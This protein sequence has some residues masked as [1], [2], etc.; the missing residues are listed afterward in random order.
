MSKYNC[1]KLLSL[2]GNNDN[3]SVFFYQLLSRLLKSTHPEDLQAANRLIKT[4]V[5][6][7]RS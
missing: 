7:V 1:A 2:T 4:M 3:G 5:R 6:Q